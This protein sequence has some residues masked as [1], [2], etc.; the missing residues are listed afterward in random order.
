MEKRFSFGCS[1]ELD[2][3]GDSALLIADWPLDVDDE[4]EDEVIEL[5]LLLVVIELAELLMLLLLPNLNKVELADKE[6][7]VISFLSLFASSGLNENKLDELIVF[8]L[9]FK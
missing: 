4:D 5:T 7:V 6:F 1:L 3:A 8:V 2:L 9:P